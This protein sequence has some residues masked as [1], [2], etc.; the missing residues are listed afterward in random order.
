MN[1]RNLSAPMRLATT[2]LRE[3]LA[4]GAV[5]LVCSIG[6]A[7]S[8]AGTVWLIKEFLEKILAAGSRSSQ[9]LYAAAAV[10]FGVW[11]LTTLFEYGSKVFQQQLMRRIEFSAMMKVVR[12]LLTL[13]VGF[14]D[15]SSHGDLVT[16]CRG[17]ITGIR[18]LVNAVCLT[19]VSGLSFVALLTAAFAL[20]PELTVW[21]LIALPI[22][23][24]PVIVLG[25]KVRRMAE[26]RRTLGFKIYDVLTQVF[27]GIRLVKIYEAEDREAAAVRRLGETYYGTLLQVMRARALA[28]VILETLAGFGVVMVVVFG[29]LRVMQGELSWPALLA[30]LMVLMAMHDPLKQAVHAQTGLKEQMPGLAR[31]ADVLATTSDVRDRPGARP[32][33]TEPRGMTFENVSFSYRDG[34]RVLEDISL[35]VRMGETVGVVGPSG[36]GKTTL[37]GL[38][39][40][41][42][43][44]THGRV[45][46]D[47]IDMRDIRLADLMRQFAI[48]TQDPFLFNATI[49][50]NIRYGRPDATEDEIIAAARAAMIDD[51]IR[52]LPGGYDAMVGIGGLRLSGGQRQRINVARALLK[53]APILFLDEA[54]SS[55]DSVA[56]MKVQNA[57]ETLMQGRTCMVIAHRLSTLR[58]ADRIVVLNTGRI[59]A[60]GRHE[61][62]L[63]VN[64]TY[65]RLWETQSRMGG[66]RRTHAPVGVRRAADSVM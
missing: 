46:V 53:N 52:G 36:A 20:S 63:T 14:F 59:E 48:V 51:E 50:D 10:I 17:D 56:E 22:V 21:G 1:V 32:L 26:G 29:G 4:A 3:N 28:G 8:R 57:I 61:D 54:T 60:V 19:L 5:F 34:T 40:R 62:L 7:A 47:G 15:R 13:S 23:T 49:R 55:L 44:P 39:A 66:T 25:A 30:F 6:Q 33:R 16:V 11:F 24:W 64:L 18:E 9:A 65:R 38:A 42:F 37:L 41:L 58:N 12:H 43:D 35:E 31:L 27:S 2:L 45:T